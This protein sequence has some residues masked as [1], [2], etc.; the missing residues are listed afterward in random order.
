A[1]TCP[2][3]GGST[4]SSSASA[5]WPRECA[6]GGSGSSGPV[7]TSSPSWAP[8]TTPTRALVGEQPVKDKDHLVDSLRYLC[9]SYARI[10]GVF[11]RRPGEPDEKEEAEEQPREAAP[12][13]EERPAPPPRERY[14]DLPAERDD[15]P[16]PEP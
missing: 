5:P 13:Q 10:L 4:P 15:P 16:E 2:R 3:A 7:P 12:Q 8:T 1:A 6:R 9:A 11:A 14:R